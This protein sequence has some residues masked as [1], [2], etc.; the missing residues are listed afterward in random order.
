MLIINDVEVICEKPYG[1]APPHLVRPRVNVMLNLLG[2][3][4]N[5]SAYQGFEISRVQWYSDENPC[6]G[7]RE[8]T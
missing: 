1:R 5:G 2:T 6:L 8:S 7:T 3:R 4:T